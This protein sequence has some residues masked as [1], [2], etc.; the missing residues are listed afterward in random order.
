MLYVRQGAIVVKNG[1]IVKCFCV[2]LPGGPELWPRI[3]DKNVLLS[4]HICDRKLK[5]V[6]IYMKKPFS[7]VN[8]SNLS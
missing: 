8:R 6:D 1:E 5:F 7:A 4:Y 3:Y 2:G